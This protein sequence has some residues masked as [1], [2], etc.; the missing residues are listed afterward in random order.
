MRVKFKKEKLKKIPQE[1]KWTDYPFDS[2]G[3]WSYIIRTLKNKYIK[4]SPSKILEV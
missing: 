4:K 2:W 1:E 3:F